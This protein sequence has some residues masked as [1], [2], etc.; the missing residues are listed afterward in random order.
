M[1]ENKK[2]GSDAMGFVLL[3]GLGV[4]ITPGLLLNYCFGRCRNSTGEFSFDIAKFDAVTIL[5]SIIV[6]GIP[7]VYWIMYKVRKKKELMNS[8]QYTRLRTIITDLGFSSYLEAFI[9]EGYTDITISRISDSDLQRL[10]ICK[11]G[12]RMRILKEFQKTNN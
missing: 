12:D 6:W 7:L 2:D 5:F 1:S 8:D 3:I 11:V 10:G 4:F 9:N